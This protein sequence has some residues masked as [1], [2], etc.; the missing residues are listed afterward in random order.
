[1]NH[2]WLYEIRP[3]VNC[4]TAEWSNK[5]L[6]VWG[7]RTCFLHSASV[8]I[9]TDR[10]H[11]PDASLDL[12]LIEFD[13]TVLS[14]T[15]YYYSSDHL[16]TFSA[17]RDTNTRTFQFCSLTFFCFSSVSLVYRMNLCFQVT[18]KTHIFQDRRD[19]HCKIPTLE[20]RLLRGTS[21]P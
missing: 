19:Q 11:R 9:E 12:K 3:E 6:V 15:L 10:T 4:C 14:I 17:L 8:R 18:C 16:C 1:M 21:M 2:F 5:A 13:L 20:Q 7:W